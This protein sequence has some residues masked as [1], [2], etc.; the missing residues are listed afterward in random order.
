MK[1]EAQEHS[2][3]PKIKKRTTK[4]G[5]LSLAERNRIWAENKQKKIIEQQERK[6]D[7]GIE[8]C[9]FAPQLATK[10]RPSR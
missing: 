2:F 10:K 8:E 1:K 6:K 3:K 4:D 9:T 5:H 7:D